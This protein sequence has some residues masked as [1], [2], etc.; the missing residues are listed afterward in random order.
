[1]EIDRRDFLISIGAGLVSL[2]FGR[3]IIAEEQEI[4]KPSLEEITEL[5]PKWP[6]I[7]L[8]PAV[9][10]GEI[11]KFDYTNKTT[12]EE[13]YKFLD[14]FSNERV[15][16]F[17]HIDNLTVRKNKDHWIKGKSTDDLNVSSAS[18]IVFLYLSKNLKKEDI[19]FF[20]LNLKDFYGIENWR[21]LRKIFNS[22][23][24]DIPSFVEYVKEKG[25]YKLIEIGSCGLFPEDIIKYIK[26]NVEEY[27]KR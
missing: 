26:L 12:S 2:L 10:K 13:F 18:A 25:K 1:M 9:E 17:L 21:E 14:R 5:L 4:I 15:F 3:R 27:S 6:Q 11:K 8:Q 19:G 16:G 7:I 24:L 23:G 20:F 22:K